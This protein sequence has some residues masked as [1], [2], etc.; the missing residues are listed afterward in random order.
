MSVIVVID[1]VSAPE[2]SLKTS[3]VA[4]NTRATPATV[5]IP[6]YNTTTTTATKDGQ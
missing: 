4:A 2:S 1:V 5:T 6:T 3:A